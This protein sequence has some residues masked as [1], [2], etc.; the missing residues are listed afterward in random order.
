MIKILRVQSFPLGAIN[1]LNLNINK[2]WLIGFIEAEGSFTITKRGD[3]QFVI[4]QGYNNIH[5]LYK[6]KQYFG[7]GRV[8]KQ[9]KQVFRFVVQDGLYLKKVIEFLNG[10]LIL[11]NKQTQL[12]KF[13]EAYN[14][15][16]NDNIIIKNNINKLTKNDSWLAGFI[17]GDGCFN[18]TY[19]PITK[20]FRI[21]FIIS[22]KEDLNFIKELF[23]GIGI[24]SYDKK[25]DFWEY[26]ICDYIGRKTFIRKNK[27]D[28]LYLLNDNII[29]YFSNFILHTSKINSFSLWFY[30]VNQLRNNNLTHKKEK[31]LIFLL[32]YI[33][34]GKEDTESK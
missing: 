10:Y 4:T 3:L 22:Q 7:Y 11:K 17:D 5:I 28:Y 8:I 6:I 9:S 23:D 12:L 15:F 20:V 19:N 14:L 33:N 2:D 16:Y 1:C 34:L 32:K 26:R 30:I 25:K 27:N 31:D 21:C 24:V 13:I 29:Y 18:I